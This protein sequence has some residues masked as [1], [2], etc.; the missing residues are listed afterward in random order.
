MDY[1]KLWEGWLVKGKKDPKLEDVT[2]V[3]HGHGAEFDVF[4]MNAKLNDDP[5]EVLE[6]SLCE[7]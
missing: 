1:E 6:R 7:A 4:K 3:G 2:L 5:D